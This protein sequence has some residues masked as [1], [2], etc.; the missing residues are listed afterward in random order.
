LLSGFVLRSS[1]LS[2]S[3]MMLQPS[4]NPSEALSAYEFLANLENH[5]FIVSGQSRLNSICAAKIKVPTWV[6]DPCGYLSGF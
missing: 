2:V 1:L 3:V 5:K 4:T 6:L